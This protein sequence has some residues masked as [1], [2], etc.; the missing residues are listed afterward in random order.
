MLTIQISMR[1]ADDIA[2]ELRQR[3]NR[4]SVVATEFPPGLQRN[5]V[6]DRAGIVERL[7]AM[8][9]ARTMRA[10]ADAAGY[11]LGEDNKWRHQNE[12]QW[13]FETLGD[14]CEH[15]DNKASE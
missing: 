5:G 8:I 11:V 9:Q 15:L 6:L 2:S 10:R 14:L 13:F 1:E 7:A 12:P 3:A 4:L